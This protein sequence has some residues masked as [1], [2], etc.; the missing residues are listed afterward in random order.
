MPTFHEHVFFF[1]DAFLLSS[2]FY[3][4]FIHFNGLMLMCLM[5]L[6]NIL[7]ENSAD[8][9]IL[10]NSTCE[11]ILNKAYCKIDIRFCLLYHE[12]KL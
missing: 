5:L 4:Y 10:S 9:L 8:E 7:S 3:L 2:L 12:L 1:I 11:L 6:Y